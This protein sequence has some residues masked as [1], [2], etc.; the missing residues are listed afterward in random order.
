MV[1]GG[2]EEYN[3]LLKSIFLNFN[4]FCANICLRSFHQEGKTFFS[5]IKSYFGGSKSFN[6]IFSNIFLVRILSWRGWFSKPKLFF[7]FNIFNHNKKA[8]ISRTMAN[9][10]FSRFSA[11]QN[12]ESSSS[13]WVFQ[14]QVAAMEKQSHQYR[15]QEKL[16]SSHS[17]LWL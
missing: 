14:Y 2:G 1:K 5:F 15:E 6:S 4:L 17:G 16:I 13:S 8:L 11:K 7:F 12:A 3:R 10:E 9:E